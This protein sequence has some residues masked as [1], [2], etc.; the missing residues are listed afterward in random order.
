MRKKETNK[1]KMSILSTAL[2]LLLLVCLE[3][4]LL[5]RDKGL[6]AWWKF[7][8]I[9]N[10]KTPDS[11][12]QIEDTIE[13]NFKSS[14]GVVG[15]ALK[16][17]GFTTCVIRR[18][19]NSPQLADKFSLESWLALATY[20]W[21]WCPIISQ[22]KGNEAGFY[23]A[24]GPRGQLSLQI[25]VDGK[26]QECTSPDFAIPLRKWAH[27]VAVYDSAEGITIY[28]DGNQVGKL[29]VKGKATFAPD[30]DLRIGMNHEKVKPAYIHREHGT[31][32]DWFSLDGI[33]DEIKI[34]DQAIAPEQV[35]ASYSKNRPNV[36][37]DLPLRLMPSGPP[38]PG[39]FGAYYCKLKYYDEWDALWPVDSHP[40]VVVRFD[41]SAAR[42]VF[43]R[44]TRYSPVWVTENGLWMADQSVEAWGVGPEDKEGCFE[45]MQDRHCRYSHVRIIENNAARV[46]VHWRY[47]PVSS[48]NHLWKEDEKTGWACWVDEYY[49][50]YPDQMGIRKVSWKKGSLGEPCQFQ[51][52]LPLL[53]PGQRQKDVMNVDFAYVGNMKGESRTFSYVENPKVKDKWEPR[54]F[55]MQLI[56]F[57]SK[58]KPFI[59]FEPGGQMY[60][61]DRN[62]KELEEG[63]GCDHWPVGLMRCDGRTNQAFDRPTHFLSFP[64]TDPPVHESEDR[65]WWNGLYGLADRPFDQLMLIAKSWLSAPPVALG[66]QGFSFLGYD[67]SERAYKIVRSNNEA[68][69]SLEMKIKAGKESPLYNPA[70]VIMNWGEKKPELRIDGKLITPGK[71]FRYGYNHRLEGTD[72]IVWLQFESISPCLLQITPA[73]K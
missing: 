41:N 20:P 62:I 21:N 59:I 7:D 57:R 70:L 15:S 49:F 5:G 23:F 27:V 1:G 33:V 63:T 29:E 38:G 43:W 45:H 32:P 22:K 34:Y 28:L 44:G 39:R 18:A 50:I 19:G 6:V 24:V 12:S 53:Q 16:L 58:Y 37:P 54:N 52:T 64:I 14:S 42:V 11:V 2:T 35:I 26:W 72:L 9:K 71:N 8:Q 40:D 61:F 66:G 68:D 46:V 73:E 13:G 51:E 48:H 10:N 30:I 56:N 55:N 47:A 69:S 67:R 65:C 60:I 17:D 36:D 4:P 3:T 25:A 31:L